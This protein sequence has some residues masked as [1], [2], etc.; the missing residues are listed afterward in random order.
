M[1]D[2]RAHLH[3]ARCVWP[4]GHPKNEANSYRAGEGRM[5]CAECHREVMRAKRQRYYRRKTPQKRAADYLRHRKRIL[6]AVIERAE[7]R[8]AYLRREAE[9]LGVAL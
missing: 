6:P 5:R 2:R 3:E 7:L 8:V 4:C 9:R 1:S